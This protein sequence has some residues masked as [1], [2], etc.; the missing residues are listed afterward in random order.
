[1]FTELRVFLVQV[2]FIPYC[3]DDRLL[4]GHGEGGGEGGGVGDGEDDGVHKQCQ[5][6]QTRGP[7]L[8]RARLRHSR[9]HAPRVQDDPR[10][11]DRAA[12]GLL[13]LL[14]THT[15]KME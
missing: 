9:V 13:S 10:Q 12:V 14:T 8:Q 1:M 2:K 11:A 4:F 6:C 3:V 15:K 7:A 5:N